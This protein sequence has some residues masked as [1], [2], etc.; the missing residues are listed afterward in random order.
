MPKDTTKPQHSSDI[1]NQFIGAML[2]D[3]KLR[4]NS[5]K[6]HIPYDTAQKIWKKYQEMGSVENRP[7]SGRPPKMTPKMEHEIQQKPRA[8]RRKPFTT[9]ANKLSPPISDK[10]VSRVLDKVGLHR[11]VARKVPF[12]TQRQKEARLAWARE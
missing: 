6:F 2:V 7:R 10:S 12:L 8:D 11:R 5:D 3:R 1:K 4:K 9:I